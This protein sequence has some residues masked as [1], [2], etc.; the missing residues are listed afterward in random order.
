MTV[1]ELALVLMRETDEATDNTEM[2]TT[3]ESWISDAVDEV[4]G[5][6]D[7][8]LY[9]RTDSLTTTASD[10]T[11]SLEEDVKD[12]RSIR[13]VDTDE[14]IDYQDEASLAGVA[15][16]F[17][18]TGK[19]RWWFFIEPTDG[20]EQLVKNIGFSPI[21]DDA[22]DIQINVNY[23]PL[24]QP[25]IT[26]NN[27]PIR[28]EAIIAI[29]HRVRAYIL[30]NDKD[31][32]GAKMYLQMFYEKLKEMIAKENKTPSAQ[33]LRMQPRDLSNQNDRRN[34]RLDPSHFRN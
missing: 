17:E 13:H 29:K 1:N 19:P 20:T 24:I 12:V 26:S 34:A 32:E 3:V 23:H 25:L 10:N 21:P 15:E 9:K 2:V 11:Y 4:A 31:Y 5:A 22:Y 27:I 6:A 8:K 7:W 30:M 18:N 14:P 28:Q 33:I 16:D